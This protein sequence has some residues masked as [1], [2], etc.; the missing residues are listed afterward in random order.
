MACGIGIIK[1]QALGIVMLGDYYWLFKL[2]F[3]AFLRKIKAQLYQSLQYYNCIY[4]K[5]HSC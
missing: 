5:K 3:A 4:A 1:L 2:P